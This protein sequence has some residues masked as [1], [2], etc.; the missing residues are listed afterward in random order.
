MQLEAN[1]LYKTQ[2]KQKVPHFYFE[3]LKKQNLEHILF[4]VIHF[5]YKIQFPTSSHR[6]WAFVVGTFRIWWPTYTE[7]TCE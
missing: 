2:Y 7:V 1:W 4:V 6:A 5:F 3:S